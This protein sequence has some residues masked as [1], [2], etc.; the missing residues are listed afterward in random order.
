MKWY[1]EVCIEAVQFTPL[2]SRYLLTLQSIQLGIE[3][4]KKNAVYILEAYNLYINKSHVKQFVMIRS[5]VYWR[6]K[7]TI[8][9]GGYFLIQAE[10]IIK[11]ASVTQLKL[12]C[13]LYVFPLWSCS[14]ILKQEMCN[15]I[16]NPKN[17][18]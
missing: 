13:P 14:L 11:I 15:R 6:S 3:G 1:L 18:L 8:M 7:L 10:K 9:K 12:S 4:N 2:L 5:A 17:E 16:V